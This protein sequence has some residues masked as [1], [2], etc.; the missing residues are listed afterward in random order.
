MDRV[1]IHTLGV[2][3]IRGFFSRQRGNFLFASITT[4]RPVLLQQPRELPFVDNDC[5]ELAFLA[6]AYRVVARSI[7]SR[8]N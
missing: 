7:S 4:A 1:S 3:K 6:S 2:Q 5:V 8:L